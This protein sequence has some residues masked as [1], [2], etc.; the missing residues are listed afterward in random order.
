MK[1]R[2]IELIIF[3]TWVFM[4]L[5]AIAVPIFKEIIIDDISIKSTYEKTIERYQC[6]EHFIS[7]KGS[8]EN[9]SHSEYFVITDQQG[10]RFNTPSGYRFGELVCIDLTGD[11]KEELFVQLW[12]GGNSK[13]SYSSYAYLLEETINPI[14]EHHHKVIKLIDLDSDGI[15]EISSL[16]PFR[17]VA[18]LCGVCSP[19]IER[20]FCYKNNRYSDCSRQWTQILESKL[21]NSKK[22]LEQAVEELSKNPQNPFF[23]IV[24]GQ[25]I[26]IIAYAILLNNENQ[27][28]DYLKD[29]LS[30]DIFKWSCDSRGEI[31]EILTTS[32][33]RDGG[34]QQVNRFLNFFSSGL[35]SLV[36]KAKS[37]F[38][39]D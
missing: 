8:G 27:Q 17:Y 19:E 29:K 15:K 30:P 22:E 21:A 23:T 2:L 25:S 7:F 28:L 35:R 1:I 24:P 39:K 14:F 5:P 6:G 20:I 9:A 4:A 36:E 32:N 31:R 26:E 13:T 10:H 34:K 11:N 38:R 33:S 12:H 18:G 16:Y 37:G 3:I